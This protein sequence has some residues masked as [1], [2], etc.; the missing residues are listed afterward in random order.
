MKPLGHRSVGFRPRSGPRPDPGPAPSPETLFTFLSKAPPPPPPPL[1]PHL[2]FPPPYNAHSCQRHPELG[3]RIIV[4]AVLT[5][6]SYPANIPD[7]S[8]EWVV[9]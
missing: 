1:D 7:I 6:V 3:A 5:P 8:R 9:V 4:F 2:L